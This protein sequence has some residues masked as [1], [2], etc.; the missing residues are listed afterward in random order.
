MFKIKFNKKKVIY[1]LI[2]FLTMFLFPLSLEAKNLYEDEKKNKQ[3]L[4]LILDQIQTENIIE[5]KTPNMDLLIEN[6][7]FGLMNVRPQAIINTNTASSYLSL[8][9][10]VRTNA[11]ERDEW[12]VNYLSQGWWIIEDVKGVKDNISG[13]NIKRFGLIGKTLKEQGFK[14]GL[15]GNA[16]NNGKMH[17]ESALLIMDQEGKV[18]LRYIDSFPN[19]KE[20]KRLFSQLDLLVINFGDTVRAQQSEN[21]ERKLINA[22]EK[23]DQL[24]GEIIAE[25]GLENNLY[26]VITPNPSSQALRK[27]NFTLTPIIVSNP[28]ESPK[29]GVLTSSSTRRDGLVLNLDFAP[30]VLTFFGIEDFGKAIEVIPVETNPQQ[31]IASNERLYLN[32]NITRYL[33]HG[34]YIFLILNILVLLFTKR[35]KKWKKEKLIYWLGLTII[36]LPLA[37][38]IT[39]LTIDFGQVFMSYFLILTTALLI[40]WISKSLFNNFI[41]SLGVSGL[42]TAILILGDLLSGIN[43]SV[44]TPFGFNDVIVGGRFYGVNNNLMGILLGSALLGIFAL[45]Q[46]YQISKNKLAIFTSIIML[47][48]ILALS[49]LYGANVGG[50]VGAAFILIIALLVIFKHKITFKRII[51][52]FSAAFL[53]EVGFAALEV[54]INKNLTHA[55]LLF[56]EGLNNGLLAF[57]DMI[58]IKLSQIAL[59]LVLPPWN[60]VLFF[61]IY[62]ILNNF[63]KNKDLIN[64]FKEKF[65]L[66][67]DGVV[68]M[69]LGSVI[70][71]AFNDTGVIS[72]AIMLTY[73][74][75][76][77]GYL[78]KFTSR[79][80]NLCCK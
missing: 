6:G 63:Y 78:S 65:S 38:F 31:I 9:M 18:Q 55:G 70:I 44:N 64:S 50:T 34:T 1:L 61:Q 73:I 10:G 12:K 32:L 5:A 20:I 46:I 74:L 53:M 14:I 45:A 42:L 69:V 51:L 67:Y 13:N 79:E 47:L 27:G 57:I 71:F 37:S 35:L 25:F 48:I 8:G 22:I 3:A 23:A 28:F 66:F 36:N 26:M 80:E 68:I 15:I 75:I 72:S 56:K 17:R 21:S 7:G 16:D 58:L 77:F 76:P 29:G 40:T 60:I 30:T 33:L 4:V 59:M 19:D 41:L 52:I 62:V 2:F 54:A 11:P 24:L 43:Y 49:P 39:P